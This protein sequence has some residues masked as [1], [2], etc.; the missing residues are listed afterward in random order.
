MNRLHERK[1]GLVRKPVRLRWL[2]VLLPLVAGPLGCQALLNHARDLPQNATASGGVYPRSLDG[3]DKPRRSPATEAKEEDPAIIQASAVEEATPPKDAE[4]HPIVNAIPP[5]FADYS[6]DLET[7]LGLAGADNPTIALAQEAVLASRAE[8]LEAQALLLPSLN[9]GVSYND[10]QG[11][12]QTAT[13]VIRKVTRQS[14]YD[15]AGAAAVGAGTVGFPGVHLFADLA[16]AAF[17]PRAARERVAGRSFD[18]QAT[19]N[20][21]LLEAAVRYF[22]LAGAAARLQASRQSE[23]DSEQVASLTSAF[24]K[25]GQGRQSDAERA[26][27]NTLL[28]HI[29]EQR[30]E[31]EVAVAAASLA[32]VLDMDPAVRLHAPDGPPPLVQLVDPHADLESL[33]H[34]ALD[35]RPEIAARSADVAVNETLLRQ[36]RFRPLLPLLSIGYS[37]GQFGGGSDLADSRFGHF[38][39]RT[40]FDAYAVWSLENFGV[41]NWARQRRRRAQVGEAEAER[42]RTIDR[43]RREVAEALALSSAHLEEVNTARRRVQTA[44][45]SFQADLVRAKN[46]EGQLIEVLDSVNS[47]DTARQDLIRAL[48][49]YDVAQFQMF[50]A[51]GRPPFVADYPSSRP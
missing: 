51:M 8:Q 21:V 33:V 27:D 14:L 11:T 46:L 30:A 49:G 22:D 47:L 1:A 32:R 6:I 20:T 48:T 37:A 44:S 3:G 41:G 7:A 18:A 38:S 19:R 26:R 17:A 45:Q 34:I 29:A 10:H 36:E 50:V 9:A 24:A 23:A 12:L 13:G 39:G 42:T 43:V 28:L 2:A 35:N 25:H 40:D 15:G 5:P 16:D 31:E 4:T